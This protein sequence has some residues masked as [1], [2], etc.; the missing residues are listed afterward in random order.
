MVQGFFYGMETQ[1]QW[2]KSVIVDEVIKIFQM[3]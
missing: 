2:R 3:F 1:F